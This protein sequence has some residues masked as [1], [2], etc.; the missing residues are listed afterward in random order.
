M[1]KKQG[2]PVTKELFSDRFEQK[3]REAGNQ[4]AVLVTALSKRQG[5][6]VIK[7]LFSDRFEQKAREA[8]NQRAV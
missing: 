2:K 3:A 8:G 1:S 4:R 5:K 6:P 7:E